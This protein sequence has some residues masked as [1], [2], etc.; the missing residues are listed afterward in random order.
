M[1]T[2]IEI[3]AVGNGLMEI[4]HW[5]DNAVSFAHIDTFPT[6]EVAEFAM[7]A[8]ILRAEAQMAGFTAESLEA[9]CGGD[10]SRHL[11]ARAHSASTQEIEKDR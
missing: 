5:L 10:I 1:R 9:A 8:G 4:M 11:M 2:I 3:T 7:M 6:D